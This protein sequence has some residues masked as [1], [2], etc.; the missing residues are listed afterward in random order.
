MLSPD[1]RGIGIDV[2]DVARF[3]VFLARHEG[4]LKEIFTPAELSAA[5]CDGRRDLY[6]AT[7]WALKEAVLKALG[8][9]W[10]RGVEWTDV[11]V[12]G[13]LFDPRIVLRGS[14]RQAAGRSGSRGAVG[15]ASSSEGTLI[16]VAALTSA[17]HSHRT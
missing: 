6:L 5:A 9:G 7:R 1:V 3:E 4:R 11:E 16:A 17:G 12:V 8:T 10:G 13:G 15:S 14:A 2:L